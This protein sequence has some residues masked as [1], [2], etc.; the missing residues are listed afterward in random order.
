MLIYCHPGKNQLV[1]ATA[2][3][4]FLAHGRKAR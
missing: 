1:L 2:G 4:H 3:Y